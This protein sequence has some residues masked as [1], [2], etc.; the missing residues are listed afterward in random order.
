MVLGDPGVQAAVLETAR[1]GLLRRGLGYDWSDV[2]VITNITADHLGPGRPRHDR[3]PRARQGAGRRARTGRR[4]AGAQRRR[5]VGAEPGRPA[6]GAR[7]PQ[8]DRLVRPRSA[9]A[10]DHRAPGPGR[11]RVPAAGRLA[12][13]G[14]RR[15]ADAAAAVRRPARRVRRS[16]PARRRERA[17]RGG[18]GPGARAPAR[19]RWSRRLADFDPAVAN[20]GRATLLRLGDVS[21]FVDYAHNPAALAATLRTLHRLWGAERCVAAV[22]LP[23]DRR[24]DLL[25]AC[26]QVRGRRGGPGRALRR[27]GPARSRRRA[28]CP[29]WSNGRCGPAGRSCGRCGPTATGRRSREALRLAG[30]G[31]VVLVLYEKLEPVLALLPELGA[32]PER[33]MPMPVVA[34]LPVTRRRARCRATDPGAAHPVGSDSLGSALR[35]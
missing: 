28:R 25:A 31:D 9:A 18:R 2:G 23:G 24:D 15:P 11:D 3:G 7:R 12:G 35:V 16:G 10:G 30:P 21:L 5:P 27:R 29:R 6:P 1:G 13:A 14:D 17:R 34:R 26:A 8:A 20:P 22:T 19:S 32:V 33:A 4:H